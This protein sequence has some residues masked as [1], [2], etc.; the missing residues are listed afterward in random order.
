MM[1][2]SEAAAMLG[3][4][5]TGADAEV[6]RVSTDSRNVQPGDLFIALRGAK[7]DGFLGRHSG[8]KSI[9]NTG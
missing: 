7:F 1:Q 2:L 4:T 5:L 3:A 6:L 8:E 9:D